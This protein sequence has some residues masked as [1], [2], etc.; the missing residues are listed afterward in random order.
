MKFAWRNPP[1]DPAAA[2]GQSI[3]HGLE[4]EPLMGVQLPAPEKKPEEFKPPETPE[5]KLRK[6]RANLSEEVRLTKSEILTK[7]RIRELATTREYNQETL[8]DL[9]NLDIQK[10]AAEQP[11]PWRTFQCLTTAI[12]TR[13]F[14]EKPDMRFES[15]GELVSFL[16]REQKYLQPGDSGVVD[17]LRNLQSSP[18]AALNIDA[19][20]T[21]PE[22]LNLAKEAAPLLPEIEK[23][24]KS[25]W[26]KV[27]EK[28]PTGALRF[29]QEH[30]TVRK[31]AITAGLL[32]AACLIGKWIFGRKKQTADSAPSAQPE[33]SRWFSRFLKVATLGIAGAFAFGYAKRHTGEWKQWLK[34]LWE[35]PEQF[36]ALAKRIKLEPKILGRLGKESYAKFMKGNLEGDKGWG[37]VATKASEGL[38]VDS[39]P[40]GYGKR[41]ILGVD[42]PFSGLSIA[43]VNQVRN[44]LKTAGQNQRVQEALKKNNVDLNNE[45]TTLATVF[46]VLNDLEK[47]GTLEK[48]L[49]DNKEN[50]DNDP[51]KDV[52]VETDKETTV[53]VASKTY[54]ELKEFAKD[55]A[56]HMR[57]VFEKWEKVGYAK[58]IWNMGEFAKDIV[59]AAEKEDHVALVLS[60]S[61]IVIWNGLKYVVLTSWDIMA[62]TFKNAAEAV[63]LDKV[64]APDVVKAYLNRTFEFMV[65][66]GAIGLIRGTKMSSGRFGLIPKGVFGG[67]IPGIL[68]GAAKGAVLPFHVGYKTFRAGALV[69]H[70]AQE[71]PWRI[72]RTFTGAEA[73]AQYWGEQAR[74]EAETLR[75][76]LRW[77]EYKVGG[78]IHPVKSIIAKHLIPEDIDAYIHRYGSRFSNAYNRF[79]KTYNETF[80]TDIEA[81]TRRALTPMKFDPRID[82][83]MEALANLIDKEFP[84][85]KLG[86][87]KK[88]ATT[89]DEALE[90]E[91]LRIDPKK[92][93]LGKYWSKLSTWVGPAAAA[94]TIYHLE[95]AE[96][97]KKAVAETAL[98]YAGFIGGV[99]VTERTF[100][101]LLKNPIYHGIAVTLGGI[102]GSMGLTGGL[103]DTVNDYFLRF[104]GAYQA[105]A[106]IAHIAEL[107]SGAYIAKSALKLA[108]SETGVKAAEKIGIKVGLKGLEEALMKKLVA[109]TLNKRLTAIV[110]KEV[111]TKIAA[112]IGIKLG[113]RG[114]ILVAG[115]A[116]PGVNLIA[117]AVD[118][119]LLPFLAKDIY[120]IVSAV[121]NASKLNELM[122]QRREYAFKNVEILDPPDAKRKFE[123][124]KTAL[125]A[126]EEE[127]IMAFFSQFPE[128]K[129]KIIR[130]GVQG[131]E[132]WTFRNGTVE[133]LAINDDKGEEI[134]AMESKDMEK[135]GEKTF[136]E[137]AAASPNPEAMPQAA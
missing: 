76:W 129:I 3:K 85:T 47:T 37:W 26:S 51:E 98:G 23:H 90:A 120:D 116:I 10:R 78:V 5:E 53:T 55:E 125:M 6:E 123:E 96:D 122:R 2:G 68:R 131:S 66:G 117:L 61:Q 22:L 8:N 67:G 115:H 79:A 12:L 18:D 100:G 32:G 99:T 80:R 103:E 24:E 33:K 46:A 34:E 107:A 135:L 52:A 94:M 71:L 7:E 4:N 17:I 60:G 42:I 92:T 134:V 121:N 108:A 127:K 77:R 38:G 101:K 62:D 36:E 82:S 104:P 74:I 63:F 50:P 35:K 136:P 28:D 102:A 87:T 89:F 113:A 83:R 119:A 70:H 124:Q 126:Q 95:T 93:R 133:G 43:E 44:F 16:V 58:I 73:H 65:I 111:F 11:K 114:A 88:A 130:E 31:I 9:H 54:N 30:P 21:W 56:P 14:H 128:T 15:V 84:E 110:S 29:L 19:N 72:K 49:E 40:S 20:E 112:R 13:I 59:Q 41:S 109:S 45:T 97:K 75:R 91:K 27:I 48:A 81:G 25:G 64:T 1:Q 69:Y 106:E 105:S 132:I 86:E 118:A 39:A 137:T 57:A